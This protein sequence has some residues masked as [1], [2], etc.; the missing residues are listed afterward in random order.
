MNAPGEIAR[1]ADI[2]R[3]GIGLITNVTA[4]HLA[5]LHSVDAVAHAKGEL[6]EKWEMKGR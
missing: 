6:F 2:A 5:K 1:L 4:A 3:P